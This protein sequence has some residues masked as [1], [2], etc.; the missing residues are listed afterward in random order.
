MKVAVVGAGIAGLACAKRLTELGMAVEVF[1][2]ARGPGGRMT[3]KRT[4]HGYLDLGAQ[5]FTAREPR[6]IKQVQH[7]QQQGVVAPWLAPIWQY[8]QGKLQPSPDSQYRFIG[9][10]A[11]HSPVKQL[12]MGLNVQY[13]WQLTKLQYDAAG[14]WLTDSQARQ[15]GPFSAVVLSIP[16]AQAAAMLPA[17]LAA[18]LPTASLNPCWAVNIELVTPSGVPAGGIFVKDPAL[19]VSWLSR[20]NSKPGRMHSESWLVHFTPAFSQQHLEQ[21]D[22]FWQQSAVTCLAQILSADIS[23]KSIL[24]HRW[25]YAQINPASQAGAT[26]ALSQGLWLAGDWTKGG[27]VENA[28]LSGIDIAEQLTYG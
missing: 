2:K 7:W 25:R 1:D 26:Q 11:M 24:C 4:T 10:P 8:Q 15:T 27:R 20:Q 17:E 19:P 21:D 3:S 16:P 5:Y 18:S 22:S 14:W 6:F 12:A 9:V 23:S 28:W 13:Q